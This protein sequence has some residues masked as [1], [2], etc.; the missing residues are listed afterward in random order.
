MTH[1]LRK[2]IVFL[3]LLTVLAVGGYF[4]YMA[5]AFPS[6]R[7]EAAKHLTAPDAQAGDCYGCHVKATPKVA[8]DWYESKH[9]ITLVRCQTCHGQ[10][11]GQGAQPFARVPG[12]D[13]C[14]RCHSLAIDRMEAK[15]GKRDDC[16]T[17]H[18]NHQSAMHGN[19]YEFRQATTKTTLE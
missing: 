14:A 13:V 6:V 12:V 5:W 11:D 19:A 9:G 3:P 15:F 1:M 2:P 8:Q 18:P 4:A 17:C 7:C 16:S 10:P